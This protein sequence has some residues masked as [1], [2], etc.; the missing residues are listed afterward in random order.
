[1]PGIGT[2]T[3]APQTGASVPA[4]ANMVFKEKFSAEQ[5]VPGIGTRMLAHK[6]RLHSC[7]RVS[8]HEHG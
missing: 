4:Y 7:A 5:L 8:L 1:V 2:R 3:L 6:A